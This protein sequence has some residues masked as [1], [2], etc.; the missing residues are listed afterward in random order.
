MIFRAVERS[1]P[2]QGIGDSL[3]VEAKNFFGQPI[4]IWFVNKGRGY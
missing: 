1:K 4:F 3:G 2:S